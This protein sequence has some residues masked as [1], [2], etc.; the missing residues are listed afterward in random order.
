MAGGHALDVRLVDD[1]F[2]P[3]PVGARLRRAHAVG[4]DHAFRH[5]ARAVGLALDEVGA[6][7]ADLIAEQ[8]VVP[9]EL[10]GIRL[11]V[12]VEQQLVAV[13]AVA[14]FG[15]VGAVGY[16]E[17]VDTKR[18]PS[19]RDLPAGLYPCFSPGGAGGLY[20]AAEAAREEEI[21]ER[22][23][24]ALQPRTRV[25][26]LTWVHSGTGAKLPLPGPTVKSGLH[27]ILPVVV[28]VWAL[29]VD[30]LSPGLSAFW[31]SAYM[32]FILLTQRPLFAIFGMLVL[33]LA[34]LAGFLLCVATLPLAA[35]T[36]A[37]VAASRGGS[38]CAT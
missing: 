38:F 32:I 25:V 30:R 22:I 9:D 36:A 6:F 31:A 37:E 2:M 4:D 23:G 15:R 14:P 17:A 7:G 1:G 11:R 8:A 33:S 27:F 34:L 3:W 20:P 12:R 24:E 29:M 18:T 28:L 26:A 21:I 10:P 35:Q 16:R 5:E 19:P 13:E